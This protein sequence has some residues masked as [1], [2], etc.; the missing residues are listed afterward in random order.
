MMAGVLD[1][2]VEAFLKEPAFLLES[3]EFA[4]DDLLVLDITGELF[5]E[6]LVLELFFF[7]LGV[8]GLFIDRT[9]PE[10]DGRL[11]PWSATTSSAIPI[12][13]ATA[14]PEDEQ[15]VSTIKVLLFQPPLDP[16]SL[17]S[18]SFDTP[19]QGWH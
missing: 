2:L 19:E 5:E 13:T 4:S 10:V 12:A 6:D 18:K 14:P 17:C 1:I 9:F 7:I 8:L 3:P 16:H 11:S 15:V